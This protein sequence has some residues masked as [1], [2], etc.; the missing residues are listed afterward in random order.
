M[1]SILRLVITILLI[2]GC[3]CE[4]EVVINNTTGGFSVA[5]EGIEWL[6]STNPAFGSATEEGWRDDWVITQRNVSLKSNKL[7]GSITEH[8]FTWNN[9][10]VTCYEVSSKAIIATVHYPQNGWNAKPDNSYSVLSAFPSV[11]FTRPVGIELGYTQWWH[12]FIFRQTIEIWGNSAKQPTTG[13]DAGPIAVWDKVMNNTIIISPLTN[14]MSSNTKLSG[15]A[16]RYGLM[17]TIPKLPGGF[18]H[19]TLL[20]YNPTGLR[21]AMFS[22]GSFFRQFHNNPINPLTYNNDVTL[23]QLGY[24]TDHGA[25]YYY[26][27][28]QNKTYEDTIIEI[29]KY[30]K[31]LNIPVKYALL[32]SWWYQQGMI[33]VYFILFY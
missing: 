11:N 17:G 28:L 27:T 30:Y 12:T 24:S 14:V 26:R 22:Y 1:N 4:W 13:P 16:L 25:A 32:D 8:C 23:S 9:T 5:V 29:S 21:K 33:V 6:G 19:S 3:Q 7:M 2:V 15:Q 31:S 18:T 10:I 20:Y